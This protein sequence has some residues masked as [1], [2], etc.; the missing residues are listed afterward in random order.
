MR[1]RAPD[2]VVQGTVG[3]GFERVRDAFVAN[4]T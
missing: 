1:Q 3:H 2:A 4:L